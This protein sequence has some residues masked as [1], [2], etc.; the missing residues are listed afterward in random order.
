MTEDQM[1]Q[2][3]T[4]LAVSLCCAGAALH[5]L[6]E[7]GLTSEESLAL[8]NETLEAIGLENKDFL[9][10]FSIASIVAFQAYDTE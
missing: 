10:R 6:K 8:I 4:K 9:V 5:K 3:T 7:G 2:K 1:M